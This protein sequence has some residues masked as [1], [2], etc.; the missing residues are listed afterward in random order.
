M[1]TDETKRVVKH[2]PSVPR[3]L[4]LL[5]ARSLIAA[6]S[7]RSAGAVKNV[8]RPPTS[9]TNGVGGKAKPCVAK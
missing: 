7:T 4:S 2:R 3:M 6:K 8:T 9:W 5:G 1:L